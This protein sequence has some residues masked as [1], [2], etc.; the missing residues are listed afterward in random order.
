M[1]W[2]LVQNTVVA[3]VLAAAVWLTCR[4]RR[5]SPTVRHALW[6]V[7]LIKLVTPPLV[8][9]PW[10]LPSGFEFPSARNSR[11]T[12][13]DARA[14]PADTLASNTQ[15][16]AKIDLALQEFARR[17]EAIDQ[18][19]SGL[20]E[21]MVP[22]IDSTEVLGAQSVEMDQ[23]H[24]L[25]QV[26]DADSAWLT[27]TLRGVFAVAP[28]LWLVGVLLSVTVHSIQ[29]A[30]FLSMLAGSLPAPDALD[31][32]VKLLA[33]TLRLSAPRVSV[34]PQV[35][36]PVIW[37]GFQTRLIWPESLAFD[38]E[39]GRWDGVIAHELAHV[40]RGDHW[41]GWIDLL[42][43]C[44]YWWNPLFW[45]V[46][47]QL[48]ENSELACDAAV[49]GA[50]P[51]GRRRYAASL[52]E[53]ASH[54]SY[55][56]V[57]VPVLGIHRLARQAFE[58]RLTMIL[59]ERVPTKLSAA[60]FGAITLFALAALPGWS[61]AQVASAPRKSAVTSSTATA[62]PVVAELQDVL[63]DATPVAPGT[64]SPEN[65]SLFQAEPSV[66]FTPFSASISQSAADDSRID[67]LE[68]K[69]Q[70]LIDEVKAMRT[71]RNTLAR[72]AAPTAQPSL[73]Y[74]GTSSLKSEVQTLT[75]A[76]YRL[77]QA[78][79]EAMAAFLREHMKTPVEAKIEGDNL[80][81]TASPGAQSIIEQFIGLSEGIA[82]E[83]AVHPSVRY[84]AP[85]S[86]Q[87]TFFYR[88]EQTNQPA[89]PKQSESDKPGNPSSPKRQ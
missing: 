34:L 3:S 76:T 29:V 22:L 57:P 24:N 9:W 31:G 59:S 77:P 66:D 74:S 12:E 86:A 55:V 68:K 36:S 47:Y 44:L 13:P 85:S 83:H 8:V 73:R 67:T 50:L 43:G 64:L 82:P 15:S 21:V 72:V 27:G 19:N 52:I 53:V 39:S 14:T 88:N 41:V 81:V 69:L 6:L 79:A 54:F 16:T 46:R 63:G 28:W 71:N 58:R 78:K 89:Q 26:N 11:A 25:G 2:W 18:G 32:R 84:I 33:A 1:L 37:G 87:G 5:L 38:F 51:D 61:Q 80:V 40:R 7:V 45:Y 48:R 10:S 49:V 4:V 75:R 56:T 65:R 30:R 60:A 42:A 23:A 35:R 20:V 62:A 70:A 17:I